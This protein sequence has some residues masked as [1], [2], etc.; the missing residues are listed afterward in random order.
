M[1]DFS[2]FF[3]SDYAYSITT[4]NESKFFESA[5]S[6]ISTML[7][8]FGNLSFLSNVTSLK[9]RL[10]STVSSNILFNLLIATFF[11]VDFYIASTTYP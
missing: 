6:K 4:Y 11:P 10:Q 1:G 8:R 3:K 2:N 5:G 9:I 7:T